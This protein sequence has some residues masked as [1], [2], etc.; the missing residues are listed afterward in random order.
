MRCFSPALF[1]LQ[2]LSVTSFHALTYIIYKKEHFFPKFSQNGGHFGY[3]D[4]SK[5]VFSNGFYW[6]VC[7][8]CFLRNNSVLWHYYGKM[9]IFW[10]FRAILGH[11]R[12]LFANSRYPNHEMFFP[13]IIFNSMTSTHPFSCFNIHNIQK[14]AFF[15]KNFTKWG[16][17]WV[18]RFLKQIFIAMFFN[19]MYVGRIFGYTIIY[20]MAL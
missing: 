7:T 8:K 19:S 4:F 12:Q 18:P 6:D 20:F 15:G 17:F 9:T 16:P 14:L 3:L 5:Y 13:W 11:F 1:Y 10:K 2:W